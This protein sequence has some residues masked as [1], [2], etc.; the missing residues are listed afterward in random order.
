MFGV[1]VAT[2]VYVAAGATDMRKS[3]EG[4]H[5]IVRDQLGCDPLSGHLFLFANAKRT[6]LKVLVWDGT[7]LWVC[8]KQLQKGRFCWPE[9]SGAHRITMSH[10][11]L[12]LLLN[13]IDLRETKRRKWYRRVPA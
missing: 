6:R 9:A 4:L 5:G 8:A 11:E 12:S 3:F 1:G 10:E 2:K 13:G 7:G